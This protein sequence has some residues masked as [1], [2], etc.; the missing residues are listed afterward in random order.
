MNWTHNVTPGLGTES[1]IAIWA[2]ALTLTLIVF[3]ANLI[4]Q[5]QRRRQ[6]PR[7][8][9]VASVEAIPS[10]SVEGSYRSIRI[11][12]HN[13]G[14]TK[15]TVEEIVLLRRPG[16][17][18][19][20]L[21][22]PLVRLSGQLLWRLNVGFASRKTVGL[23]VTLD[24]NGC[25]ESHIPLEPEDPNNKEE[26]RRL[27]NFSEKAVKVLRSRAMRYSIQLSCSAESGRRPA[28]RDVSGTVDCEPPH[29]DRGLKPLTCRNVDGWVSLA[30]Y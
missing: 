24:V 30:T 15:T 3:W 4:W 14:Q 6:N 13:R 28:T 23:P 10:L 27:E 29:Q 11:I 8:R 25:W 19:F 17:F 2:L 12:L 26:V 21:I 7:P 20:G 16:W 18:E 5:R 1:D 22:G 9:V